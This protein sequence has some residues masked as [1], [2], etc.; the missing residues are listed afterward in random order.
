[1]TGAGLCP[2]LWGLT[3]R[4]FSRSTSHLQQVAVLEHRSGTLSQNIL[5]SRYIHEQIVILCFSFDTFD[6]F[7]IFVIFFLNFG[8]AF[9]NFLRFLLF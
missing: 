6:V 2:F 1:M 8:L 4:P 9:F 3:R 7:Y 5:S